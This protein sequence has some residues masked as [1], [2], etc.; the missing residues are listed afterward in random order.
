[1]PKTIPA[2]AQSSVDTTQLS[3]TIDAG[4]KVI[5]GILA[6]IFIAKGVDPLI[7]STNVTTVTGQINNIIAQYAIIAPAAY[8][9]WH[10]GVMLY[11][12]GRKAFMWVFGQKVTTV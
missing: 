1:M 8:S 10:S 11:G 9:A 3:T 6:T 7:I 12:L 5:G 4:I 2:W